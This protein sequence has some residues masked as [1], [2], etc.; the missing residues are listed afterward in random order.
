M[1]KQPAIRAPLRGWEGPYFLRKYIR[2]GISS[3]AMFNSIH[4][5][6]MVGSTKG[7][8]DLYTYPKWMNRI[9]TL[10]T[11]GGEGDVSNFVRHNVD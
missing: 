2:P 5:R 10:A 9:L 8:H 11:E 3:S 4:K 7:K 6:Q 1:C